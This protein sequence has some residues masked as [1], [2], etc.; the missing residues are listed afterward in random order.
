MGSIDTPFSIASTG[1]RVTRLSGSGNSLAYFG[2]RCCTITKA[3][4][5]VGGRSFS[6]FEI[7]SNLPADPNYLLLVAAI[8]RHSAL[9]CPQGGTAQPGLRVALVFLIL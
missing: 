8:P 9:S 5:V 4:P 7:A 6:R 1:M 2:S 3:T